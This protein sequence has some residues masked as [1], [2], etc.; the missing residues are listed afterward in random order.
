MKKIGKNTYE[1]DVGNSCKATPSSVAFLWK[2]WQYFYKLFPERISCE[3]VGENIWAAKGYNIESKFYLLYCDVR[4]N[5]GKFEFF[6]LFK[7]RLLK[8]FE[9]KV[10]IEYSRYNSEKIFYFTKTQVKLPSIF[11][12]FMYFFHSTINSGLAYLNVIGAEGAEMI[13]SNP[14]ILKE[15]CGED[16]YN[17]YMEFLDEE[18]RILN[19]ETKNFKHFSESEI[20]L[21]EVSNDPLI[22]LYN[23]EI[24]YFKGK[25]QDMYNDLKSSL[26]TY[27]TSAKL[28]LVNNRIVFEKII[29]SII[30]DEKIIPIDIF[31]KNGKL[32]FSSTDTRLVALCE[33]VISHWKKTSLTL[34]REKKDKRES[35]IELI[36]TV[37]DMG[38]KGAHS[39]GTSFFSE[40]FKVSFQ[41]L[42][43]ICKWYVETYNIKTT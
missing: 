13:T 29:K 2:N 17:L 3:L 15:K 24:N 12:P 38:N 26:E 11:S 8:R 5:N 6:S 10:T 32:I 27:I 40:S 39:E 22:Y 42:L 21:K 16:A 1:I 33:Q 28:A 20:D 36:D 18:K 35:I 25:N 34:T 43:P 14:E 9:T 23:D 31:N 19:G 4:V 7:Y 30:K 37:R 41:A